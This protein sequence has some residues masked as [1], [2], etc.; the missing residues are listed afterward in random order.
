MGRNDFAL[1]ARVLGKLR[2]KCLFWMVPLCLSC[3]TTMNSRAAAIRESDGRGVESCEFVGTARGSSYGGI[4]GE[5]GANNA[6]NEAMEKAAALGATRIVWVNES[7][8]GYGQNSTAI[9][10]AYR[11]LDE[12][13]AIEGSQRCHPPGWDTASAREK[14]AMLKVC[15]EE[16]STHSQ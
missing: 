3:V 2:M 1:T 10:R 16:Q 5:V 8:G 4:A 9:A 6:R 15:H 13:T 14:A 12:V 7:Q 11:C